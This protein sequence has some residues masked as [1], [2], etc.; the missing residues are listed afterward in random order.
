MSYCACFLASPFVA[1]LPPVSY[2]P[3]F[4]L[5]LLRVRLCWN[6]HRYY[7][8]LIS[9]CAFYP[10]VSSFSLKVRSF[11]CPK[12]SHFFCQV[13]PNTIYLVCLPERRSLWVSPFS[14]PFPHLRPLSS[15]PSS[16]SPYLL[17]SSPPS[18]FLLLSSPPL[19]PV[20]PSSS[21][22]NSSL[23]LLPFL[24]APPLPFSPLS[25][26]VM[27]GGDTHSPPPPPPS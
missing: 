1:F 25:L 24:S 16:L 9:C 22:S 2:F 23:F 11:C 14:L 13:S 10:R 19:V 18:P 26:R 6:L 8:L 3:L 15:S 27:A 21:S 12:F 7:S 20:L 17:L 5:P 4:S